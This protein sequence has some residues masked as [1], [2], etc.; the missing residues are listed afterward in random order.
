MSIHI[1]WHPAGGPF[2]YLASPFSLYP[3]GHEKAVE[4]VG[5]IAATLIHAGVRLFC[6]VAHS[7]PLAGAGLA[8]TDHALWARVNDPFLR[9]C[10]VLIVAH[11]EGFENSSGIAR[12]VDFFERRKKPIYDLEPSTMTMVRRWNESVKLAR[13]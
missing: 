6:P 1:P 10:S 5:L 4:H 7:W 13:H 11:M 12:E 2:A 3:H 8:P 9:F